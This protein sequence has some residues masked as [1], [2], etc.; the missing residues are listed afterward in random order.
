MEHIISMLDRSL[1]HPAYAEQVYPQSQQIIINLLHLLA[2]I[3]EDEF[4]NSDPEY[5]VEILADFCKG[6]K[7]ETLLAKVGSLLVSFC[8]NVEGC[9]SF[10]GGICIMVIKNIDPSLQK[11]NERNFILNMSKVWNV[12]DDEKLSV[13]LMMLAALADQIEKRKDLEKPLYFHLYTLNKNFVF[14]KTGFPPHIIC[15]FMN[16]YAIYG[17]CG[18]LDVFLPY[19]SSLPVY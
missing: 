11:E 5:F 17:Y 1:Y 3:S 16:L 9:F 8:N 4:A 14:G 19:K 12:S 7:K 15:K 13:S 18:S 10:L 6:D 2:Q